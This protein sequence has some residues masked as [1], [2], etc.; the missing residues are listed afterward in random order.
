MKVAKKK[1]C[2]G[3]AV[4]KPTISMAVLVPSRGSRPSKGQESALE[5]LPLCHLGAGGAVSLS[6]PQV[7]ELPRSV[8]FFPTLACQVRLCL[9]LGLAWPPHYRLSLSLGLVHR[10]SSAVSRNAALALGRPA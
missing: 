9:C 6:Q 1:K 5:E 8:I 7:H 10:V 4:L 2:L 3:S